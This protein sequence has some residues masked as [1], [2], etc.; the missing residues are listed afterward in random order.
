MRWKC[1]HL[2]SAGRGA[3]ALQTASLRPAR[4]EEIT[5]QPTEMQD[6]ISWGVLTTAAKEP[7]QSAI[8]YRMH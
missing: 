8:K 4:P 7:F 5:I 6:S 2:D 1:K 3:T